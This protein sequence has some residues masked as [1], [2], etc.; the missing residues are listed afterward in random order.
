MIDKK[1]NVKLIELL[2][3]PNGYISMNGVFNDYCQK[4]INESIKFLKEAFEVNV[5]DETKSIK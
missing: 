2:Y 5:L 3:L 4:A 1:I